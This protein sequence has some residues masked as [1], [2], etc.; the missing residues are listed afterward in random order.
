MSYRRRLVLQIPS[1]FEN[2]T[3]VVRFVVYLEAQLDYTFNRNKD[4][5]LLYF[6]RDSSVVK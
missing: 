3:L 2:P 5:R 1:G 4:R 6:L